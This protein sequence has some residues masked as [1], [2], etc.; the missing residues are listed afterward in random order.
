MKYRLDSFKYVILVFNW[1]IISIVICKNNKKT[2]YIFNKIVS[3]RT[4][5]YL[6]PHTLTSSSPASGFPTLT[7]TIND[8]PLIPVFF[9]RPANFS[10][11]LFVK[12][13]L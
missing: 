4:V 8:K 1:L 10:N 6:L 2:F 3:A 5:R 11:K 9:I 7:R 12:M 13:A